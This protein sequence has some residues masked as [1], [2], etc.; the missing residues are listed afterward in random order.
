VGNW[1]N[2]GI[3]TDMWGTAGIMGYILICGE[4]L[5]KWDIY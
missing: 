5:K 4:L 2:N 1:W 3:Y